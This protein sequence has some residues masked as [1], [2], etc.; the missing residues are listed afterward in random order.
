MKG[1]VNMETRKNGDIQKL[2]ATKNKVMFTGII[3]FMGLVIFLVDYF[4]VPNPTI[5][6]MVVVV[7]AVFFG[8][9][10]C[11]ILSAAMTLL[12]S[13]YFFS[14]NHN[15]VQYSNVNLFKLE[16]ILFALIA[17]VFTTGMIKKK[18]LKQTKALEN[19]NQLLYNKTISDQLTGLYNYRYFLE[20]LEAMWQK[21]INQ[22]SEI[23]M[24]M[25]DINFF[26]KYNDYYGHQE[27]NNCISK[28]SKILRENTQAP[29]GFAARYGGEEFVVV[30]PNIGPIEAKRIAENLRSLV[31][32]SDIEHIKSELYR[33]LTISVGVAT[34]I[35]TKD[36]SFD[37]LIKRADY[38]LY[39]A[40]KAGRN[41][42]FEEDDIGTRANVSKSDGKFI[43]PS[44]QKEAYERLLLPVGVFQLVEDKVVTLLVSDGLC[45]MSGAGRLELTEH[46][47][48]DMFGGVHPEDVRML[49]E[50][51]YRFARGLGDYDVIYRTKFLGD[52]YHKLHVIGK[53]QS[54]SDD[55]SVAFIVYT[56]LKNFH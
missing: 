9:Y 37:E 36:I 29:G 4:H 38:V 25:I 17:M 30:M 53:F 49:A 47:D 31:E 35:P 39:E 55:T 50:V 16:I 18:F 13:A 21:G 15:F 1:F 45:E 2:R 51:G 48:S 28:V 22:Q 56:D 46:F 3:L 54:V 44:E 34:M 7:F 10:V 52:E 5:L 42:V 6:C 26:K 32:Q 19:M 12:Y 11:G 14:E 43:F 33:N 23:S 20:Q 41:R 8:G 24:A 40:K 27:G